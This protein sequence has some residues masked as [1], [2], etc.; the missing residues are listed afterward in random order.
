VGSESDLALDLGLDSLALVE[1]A[2]QLEAELGVSL[3]DGDLATASSVGDLLALIERGD[4]VAAPAAFPDWALRLPARAAR[5]CLQ[6]VLLFPAH[7][8]VCA[9][10][11]VEGIENLPDRGVPVLLVANHSSHLDTPSILRALPRRARSRVAVAAAADY[12][13]RTRTRSLAAPLVLNAFP[14]S[15][16][17]SVRASLERCGDLVDR[18]WSVLVYPE[19]TRSRT[20][21]LQPF[22]SG[23]GL[24]A[25]ELRVPI[26]PI[27]IEGTHALLPK[28]RRRPGRGPV[29]VRFGPAVSPA[30]FEDR[31][32]LTARL[33]AEV[34]GLARSAASQPVAPPRSS[35]RA[36]RSPHDR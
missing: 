24:L 14:F 13:F 21:E 1:L 5:S 36:A 10:F 32:A 27:G 18:G 25:T 17:G 20:G 8:L 15:R 2:V 33:A 16:E 34:A 22:R 28:G 3:E 31:A 12:F 11:R 4:V 19:G 9:P 26:V 30:T 6:A 23:I 35:L 29:T 7:A